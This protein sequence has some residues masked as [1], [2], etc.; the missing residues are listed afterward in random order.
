MSDSTIVETIV[1]YVKKEGI[2]L[3]YLVYITESSV[4]SLRFFTW[5]SFCCSWIRKEGRTTSLPSSPIFF[6]LCILLLLFVVFYD[7]SRLVLQLQCFGFTTALSTTSFT[8]AAV[9]PAL[10]ADFVVVLRFSFL[11]ARSMF[12]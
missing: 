6:P 3:L 5:F 7:L 11:I 1:L 10:V 4:L 12:L 9:L 8:F 2:L